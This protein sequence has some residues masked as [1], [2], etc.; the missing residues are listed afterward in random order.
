MN[1]AALFFI[2]AALLLASKKTQATIGNGMNTVGIRNNNPLN[3][4]YNPAN[5]WDGQID[6]KSG[7]FA[8]FSDK[9]YGYRAAFKLL[10][11]YVTKHGLQSIPGIV[12]RWAPPEDNNPTAEYIRFIVNKTGI[13]S[14][15][16]INQSHYKPIIAAMAEFESK[17]KDAAALEAGYKLAF[18]G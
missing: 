14:M 3:I 4:R 1:I 7:P 11:T 16:L 10:N 12:S 8:Y 18:G 5:D 17:D 9:K 6:A 2:G 13:P 15:V